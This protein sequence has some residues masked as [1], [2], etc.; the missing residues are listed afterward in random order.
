MMNK[1]LA[2][3][4][5]APLLLAGCS[6]TAT[7]LTPR[8]VPRNAS[9][10]YPFEAVFDTNQ[11]S[12][13]EETVKAYVIVGAETYPMQP[14]PLL[15]NRF[16]TLVPISADT[17][18][19]NYQYKFDYEYNRIPQRGKSSKLSAPFRLELVDGAPVP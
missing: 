16:E 3:L 19:V 6:T 11:E 10:L 5:L 8:Q 7:N 1:I 12:I 15:T 14:T 9:G 13:R 4:L 17:R 18:F 2:A